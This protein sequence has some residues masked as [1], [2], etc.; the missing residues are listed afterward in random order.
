MG[1]PMNDYERAVVANVKR[2]GWHCTSVSVL[3][4]DIEPR[5][6]YTVGLYQSYRQPEFVIFGLDATVAHGI[7][8]ILANAAAAGKMFPL[9]RPCNALVR[10]YDCVFV[11][12]PRG[13]FHDYVFSALWFYAG[14]AFP[15]YQVVW[16]D[17]EGR[18]P[19]NEQAESDP[20]HAQ[21]VLA[22]A[23]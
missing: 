9:D 14:K 10:G 19:W 23:Q 7:L 15:L 8:T 20:G 16:P 21:P 5:F 13:R 12:V 18:Y 4:G 3:P 2:Y 17:R 6:S 22:M 11:E 1:I